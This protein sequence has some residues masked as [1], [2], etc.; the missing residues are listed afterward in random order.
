MIT[1]MLRVTWVITNLKFLVYRIHLS[2][3]IF[4]QKYMFYESFIL[5]RVISPQ[6]ALPEFFSP[7]NSL[8]QKNLSKKS[9]QQKLAPY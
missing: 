4:S 6:K 3:I 1:K 7:G 9:A 2:L 8:P 5:K